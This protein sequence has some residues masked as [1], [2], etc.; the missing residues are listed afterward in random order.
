MMMLLLVCNVNRSLINCLHVCVII[1]HLSKI[2]K[3]KDIILLQYIRFLFHVELV[4]HFLTRLSLL[5]QSK[6]KTKMLTRTMRKLTMRV[7]SCAL[8]QGFY[9]EGVT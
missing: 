6:I 1:I 8:G 9:Q 7:A 4:T 2:L 3:Y 5:E